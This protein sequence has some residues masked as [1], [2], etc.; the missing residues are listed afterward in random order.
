MAYKYLGKDHLDGFDKY[1][2]NAVDT[3]PISIYIMHPFWNTC[4]KIFPR[5]LAPNLM[6]FCGCLLLVLNFLLLSYYDWD[7][8]ASSR[9]H[10]AYPPVPNIIWLT[11]GVCQFVAHQLDGMDGK[12]ARRTNSSTPLGEL[13][14][15]GIDS[16]VAALMAIELYS[17]FSRSEEDY[18]RDVHV[19]FWVLWNIVGVF[20][21]SHWEKYNTGVLFLPWGYDVSQLSLAAVYF[22]TGI[23]GYEFW[24]GTIFGYEWRTVI[25]P[26]V[27]FGSAGLSVPQSVY[28]VYRGYKDGT[29]KMRPYIQA[30]EPLYPLLIL[31]VLSVIWAFM[32]PADILHLHPR[33]FCLAIGTINSNIACRLI[34]SQMSDTLCNKF[35]LLLIPL[36]ACV[37]TSFLYDDSKVEAYCL[38][39]L[40]TVSIVAQVHYA[41]CVVSQLAD[42]FNIYVF[43]LEKV[44]Q[45]DR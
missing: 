2:Y 14:D 24:K 34:I 9:L 38:F 39:A 44:E 18:G 10:P 16:W 23:C 29:G 36:A 3:S 6:T 45:R 7:Y 17:C 22:V 27:I 15:H 8:Y 5:W 19:L 40:C 21:I 43:S 42:H 11:C 33:I 25:V 1:K 37:L 13:F 20:T 12:Q 28:N 35:N 4:V 41:S 31:F 26:A 30:M 32:S